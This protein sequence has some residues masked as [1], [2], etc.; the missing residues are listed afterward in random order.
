MDEKDDLLF[1]FLALCVK[2][3]VRTT[4]EVCYKDETEESAWLICPA[5]PWASQSVFQVY[6]EMGE[7]YFR[8]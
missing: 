1:Q 4:A 8:C 7:T 6:R 5:V 2:V 3:V